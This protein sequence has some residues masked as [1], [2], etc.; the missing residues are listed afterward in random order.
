MTGRVL[1]R[2]QQPGSTATIN[3]TEGCMSD[4]PNTENNSLAHAGEQL[5]QYAIDRADMVAILDALPLA[6]PE[7][8]VA[9]EYEIQLLRIISVGW[10]IS[11][12]LADEGPKTELGRQFWERVRTFST[13]LSTSASLTVGADIDYFDIL[14]QRL[15]DYV[16]ALDAAGDIP[17]PAMAIGPAF[18]GICGD[19]DD[20]CA[21]LAG[22]KMF[23][24]TISAVREYLAGTVMAQ[25]ESHAQRL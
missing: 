11:F 23:S 12:F 16:G 6:V 19:R 20:A 22:T 25:P 9:L 2:L 14:R 15:D 21:I 7:K 5:F 17:E 13:T 10:A 8:R 4:T 3:S 18:A 24:H 1:A